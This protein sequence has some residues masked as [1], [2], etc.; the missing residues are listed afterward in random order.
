M[1]AFVE[2]EL[3]PFRAGTRVNYTSRATL[4][5]PLL[6]QKPEWLEQ[7]VVSA[8]RQTVPCDVVV[9]CSHRTPPNNLEVLARLR[10]DYQRLA[11]LDTPPD[12]GYG[13]AFN[14][15]IEHACTERLG[16]LLADD[17]L[18]PDAV[19]CCL[20]LDADIV[21]TQT[22]TVTADGETRLEIGA[23][24]NEGLQSRRSPQEKADY[25]GHFLLFKR[26]LLLDAGGVDTGVG[27]TGPDDYDLL[28]TLLERGAT[29]MVVEKPLYNYRDHAEEWR[30]SLR[31]DQEQ[32]EDL[33]RIFDKH[34]LAPDQ[35]P[36]LRRKH[37][38]WFGKTIEQVRRDPW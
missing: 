19:E 31:P 21:S 26:Q 37:G 1:L 17:W 3:L 29:A 24:S 28:W 5:I 33:E 6:R 22:T 11:V 10:E 8:L 20:M 18:E 25:L 7:S 12:C 38:R 16:F 13:C 36:D 30:L 4:V 15:G 23:I 27:S 2:L 35:R 14:A 9:V 34:G 32:Y